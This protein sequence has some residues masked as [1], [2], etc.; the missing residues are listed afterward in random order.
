MTITIVNQTWALDAKQ[1]A[2]GVMAA[3][4]VAIPDAF[5]YVFINTEPR[6]DSEIKQGINRRI[7]IDYFYSFEEL[8][9][10]FAFPLT[11]FIN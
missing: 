7:Y 6:P 4:D 1:Y 10:S 5:R 3:G 8:F 2:I 11:F 9:L